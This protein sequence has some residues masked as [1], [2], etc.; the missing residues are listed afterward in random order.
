MTQTVEVD[1]KMPMYELTD[2]V[3]EALTG[4]LRHGGRSIL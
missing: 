4:E 3:L 2:V 1:A